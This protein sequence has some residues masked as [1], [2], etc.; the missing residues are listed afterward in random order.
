ME[1]PSHFVKLIKTK[2]KFHFAWQPQVLGI[3]A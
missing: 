2:M 3:K 1:T